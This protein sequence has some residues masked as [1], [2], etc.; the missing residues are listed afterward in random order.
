MSPRTSWHEVSEAAMKS[1]VH[2]QGHSSLASSMGSHVDGDDHL[3][4]IEDVDLS[5][6]PLDILIIH[7]I[8]CK[9]GVEIGAGKPVLSHTLDGNRHPLQ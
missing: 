9:L 1:N 5:E 6:P 4:T 7:A 2:R 8:L 3:V